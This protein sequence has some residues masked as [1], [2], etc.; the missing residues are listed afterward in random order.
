MSNDRICSQIAKCHLQKISSIR[1]GVGSVNGSW[2]VSSK[3]M[4]KNFN[5]YIWCYDCKMD[6]ARLIAHA[7]AH[8]ASHPDHPLPRHK[9]QLP[10]RLPWAR[11]QGYTFCPRTILPPPEN[12]HTCLASENASTCSENALCGSSRTCAQR[13]CRSSAHSTCHP[14][15]YIPLPPTTAGSQ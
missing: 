13:G 11:A 1:R 7:C 12:A 5:T 9:T 3:Y 6:A 2:F 8:G 14:P 4:Y 15:R 10:L